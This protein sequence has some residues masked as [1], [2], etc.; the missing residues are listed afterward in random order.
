MKPKQRQAQILEYL[1]QKG[2]VTVEALTAHFNTTGTTIRKDLSFLEQEGA[3]I[4]TYGGVM[5]NRDEGDQPID[6]KTLI[7]TDK[8]KQ[9]AALAAGLINEGDSL[10]FDAGSTVLQMVPHLAR[11]NNITVMT[12]SLSIVNELVE[13]E[14]DQV[15]LMP[16]GTYRKT[17]ASFH[18]SLAETAFSHFSFDKLF[19]GADGVD[20]AA[21]V[22]TFNE[23][24]AV[25]QAMCRAAQKIVLLVDSSKFGRKSPNVVCQLASVDVLITD[26]DIAPALVTQLQEK[27]IEVLIAGSK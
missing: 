25:S 24:F 7:N 11:F 20:L 16:G 13:L 14:N 2:R 19:I 27:G 4:R 10:I 26:S 15:I 6:R 18:G 12:N 9:I 17:S 8:K 21:G 3:V 5:L 22:T 23:V 1:Q